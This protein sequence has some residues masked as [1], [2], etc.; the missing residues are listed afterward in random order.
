MKR[1]KHG[2]KVGDLY[3][4]KKIDRISPYEL[5]LIIDINEDTGEMKYYNVSL[6]ETILV[7][8][9]IW[10]SSLSIGSLEFFNR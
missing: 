2:F 5:N 1:N 3:Q 9:D 7:D 6:S 4:L 10:C 8:L